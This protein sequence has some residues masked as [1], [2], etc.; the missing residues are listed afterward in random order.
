MK[1]LLFV[2]GALSALQ[3]DTLDR[4]RLLAESGRVEEA[5]N[6]LESRRRTEPRAPELAYLAQLYAT[7]G[8][9]PQAAAALK[10]ALSL[11]P[12]QDGLRVTLGAMLFELR[13]Y[14]EARS[15]LE[16]AI[17]RRGGL[18]LAQYYLAA[19]YRGLSRLDLAETAALRAIELSPSP[20]RV[21][22]D[23]PA[24]APA[25]AA[26]HLLAEIRFEAGKE[27]EPLLRE[28]LAAEPDLASARYLLARLLERLGRAEE[29]EEELRR[30]DRIKRAEAHLAQGLDLSR[31]G[32]REEAIAELRLAVEAHPEHARS[33]F[34]LG[35]E[36]LRA[37]RKPEALPLFERALAIRPDAKADVDRLLDSF[38]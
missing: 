5:V 6:L 7:D 3:E 26:R 37:G 13:R 1:C 33:L 24:P 15:E 31:L 38:P 9:L 28:A 23:S 29:A 35:R 32:Q 17:A 30:F 4:A 2:I 21:P 14:E 11:A 16:L 12:E 36:L 18:A 20:V 22:L 34:L 19:V 25:V 8:R 10:R 27:A